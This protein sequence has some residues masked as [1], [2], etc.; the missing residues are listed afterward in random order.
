MKTKYI[1][2]TIYLF[3]VI[4]LCLHTPTAIAADFSGNGDGTVWV[5]DGHENSST[6]G[7]FSA[8][9]E[10]AGPVDPEAAKRAAEE[11]AQKCLLPKILAIATMGVGPRASPGMH[12]PGQ[13]WRAPGS[14]SHH[15]Q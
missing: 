2:R 13:H 3:L 10:P 11:Y 1:N 8:V 9:A 5:V 4:S 6:P 14:R 7:G 15:G 12:S